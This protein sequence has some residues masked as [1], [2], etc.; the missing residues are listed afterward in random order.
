MRLIE[1]IWREDQPVLRVARAVLFP[2]EAAYRAA[3]VT[4]GWMYERGL[5]RVSRS[6]IIVVSVGN[7]SVG[8][9]G[10]TPFA[11]WLAAELAARGARPAVVLRGYGGDE[12]LVHA[13]LNPEIPVIIEKHRADGIARAAQLGAT[14]AVLDDAFQHRAATREIDIVLVAAEQWQGERRMRLLPAGPWREPLSSIKRAALVVVTR[15][16][17]NAS[18]VQ[19]LR[20]AID[21]AAPMLPQSVVRF[22]LGELRAA[23]GGHEREV[24]PLSA[25]VNRPTAAIAGVADPGAFFRQLTDAGAMVTPFAFPDHHRYSARDVEEILAAVGARDALVVCTLKDAVKLAP[26]WPATA[27]SLWYVLQTLQVE[28]GR[29]ELEKVLSQLTQDDA[30]RKSNREDADAS[31]NP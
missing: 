16:T 17:A 23:Q 19:R 13:R 6:R 8:G 31:S 12:P 3:A 26:I 14:V 4:R 1:R 7:I 2:F 22:G 15:K 20:D 9:T 5:L 27:P 29:E 11:A 30:T 28:S 10:K 25:V 21:R 24:L 18:Q